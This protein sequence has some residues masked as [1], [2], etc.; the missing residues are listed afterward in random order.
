MMVFDRLYDQS[1]LEELN[2]KLEDAQFQLKEKVSNQ[3]VEIQKSDKM[4]A[5][6]KLAW[7]LQQQFLPKSL[8]EI[9]GYTI[10]FFRNL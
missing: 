4:R 3:A 1:K 5:E 2:K 8:P 9:E 7:Q 10:D 6:Y